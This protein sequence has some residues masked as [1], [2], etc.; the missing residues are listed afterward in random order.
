MEKV[1]DIH[2][3]YTFDIPIHETIEIFK[4]EFETTKTEKFCF[5]SLPHHAKDD[6]VDF[7]EMQNIKGLFLKKTFGENA[8]AFAHL[9]HPPMH[10]DIEK[11]ADD[12]FNQAKKYLSVGYDGFK[13]LEG[14]PS[15]IKAWNLMIDSPVY[16]KFYSF[17][18]ENGYPIIIHIANPKENW[19]RAAASEY[20]IK[21][22]RVYDDSYPKKDDITASLLHVMEKHPDLKLITAH[23]GF[24]S[25]DIETAEKYMSY[26]NTM[27]D[28]TPGGEQL[29]LIGEKWD[30]WLHFFEKYQDR[31]LYGT[32]FYAFPKGTN[33]EVSYTRRPN[34][35][36][37][38][39]DNDTEHVYIDT[40]F[41]GVNLKK[42]IR[43]KIYRENFS[44]IFKDRNPIN[45]EYFKSELERLSSIPNKKSKHANADIKY[46]LDNF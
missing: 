39:F 21:A 5:L 2:V 36:H 34:F 14:Y 23:F 7:D 9:E 18:E 12:F 27:L 46:M 24:L 6:V 20:A 40:T 44:K 10:N 45:C 4:D 13:M 25:Y 31:I 3:H 8:Y 26:P 17:M 15:L 33:W 41:H 38:F 11:C 35:V 32:D 43:D 28:V 22:G 16:D 1:Y 29:M 37:H 30:I 19:D 42:S